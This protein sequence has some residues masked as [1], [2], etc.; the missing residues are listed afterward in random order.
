M[1][2]VTITAWLVLIVGIVLLYVPV[3]LKPPSD[4]RII[5]EHNYKT[6]IAPPCFESSNPTNYIEETKL[7]EAFKQNYKAHSEC[8][9]NELKPEKSTVLHSILLKLNIIESKWDW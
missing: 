3:N 8:T 1:R 2:K 6:Y 9:I 7:Q 4:T 5:L